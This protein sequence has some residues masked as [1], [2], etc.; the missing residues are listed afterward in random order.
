M[1]DKSS[2][3]CQQCGLWQHNFP[4]LGSILSRL[5]T[6]KEIRQQQSLAQN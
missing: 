5:G 2:V 3:I 6:E 4:G 1:G